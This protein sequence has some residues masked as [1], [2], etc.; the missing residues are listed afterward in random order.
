MESKGLDGQSAAGT[1]EVIETAG[2]RLTVYDLSQTLSNRTA[3]FEP[4]RHRIEYHTPE[5][6]ARLY[7]ATLGLPAALWPGGIFCSAETV[8]AST[9]SGTHVDAPMHYGPPDRGQPI[10]IDQVPLR[11]CVGDGVRL[12]FRDKR[13]GD[14]ITRADV[15][16]ALERISHRLKPFDIVLVWTGTD[17]GFAEPG[18]E[19][20]HPG[21]RRDATEYLVDQGVRLIGIDAWG[22]DRPFDVMVREAKAGDRAQLW[23]SHILG[24]SKPYSQIEKLCNLD[25]L[26][27]DSGFTVLALP[28]RLEAAS[29]AWA[30]VVAIFWE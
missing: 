17:R 5:E 7:E 9:H 19:H 25:R 13:A 8:T 16:R 2:R 10:G 18:Y 11:W 28:V 26:P 21:L 4:N 15:E 22:L 12:D 30:R 1:P 29:G 6:T 27:R 20:R 24:R 23:E 14:G 3:E